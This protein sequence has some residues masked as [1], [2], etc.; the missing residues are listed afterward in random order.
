M[1]TV[2]SIAYF[3][4][5]LAIVLGFVRLKAGPS[6]LD[7]ILAFDLIVTGV[8]GL[9]VLLSVQWDTPLYLEA[10]LVVSLMGFFTTV[11]F[12]FYRYDDRPPKAGGSTDN[13]PP[14]N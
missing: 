12:V 11:V 14:E 7:R 3:A 1:N 9:I 13:P 4:L 6:L 8:V 2:L 10:I 5:F